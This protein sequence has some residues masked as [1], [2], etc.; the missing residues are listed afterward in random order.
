M[1]IEATV[2]EMAPLGN[3]RK[4]TRVL[5]NGHSRGSLIAP[6][7]SKPCPGLTTSLLCTPV[8]SLGCSGGKGTGSRG[9]RALYNL[10]MLVGGV[11]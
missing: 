4:L 9:F 3:A 2:L 1:E 11:W 7:S 8:P 5:A 10:E 6:D